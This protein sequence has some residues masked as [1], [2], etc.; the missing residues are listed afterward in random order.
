MKQSWTVLEEQRLIDLKCE[1]KSYLEIAEIMYRTPDSLRK[2][3]WILMREKETNPTKFWEKIKE[4]EELGYFEEKVLCDGGEENMWPNPPEPEK[5]EVDKAVRE[6]HTVYQSAGIIRK[7][8]IWVSIF[9][10]LAGLILIV[11]GILKLF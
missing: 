10:G 2:K 9:G 3:H 5:S 4:L 8:V 6:I 1:N 7:V 11:L